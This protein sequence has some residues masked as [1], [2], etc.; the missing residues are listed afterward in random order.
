[1]E[2]F[3]AGLPSRPPPGVAAQAGDAE[4]RGWQTGSRLSRLPPGDSLNRL[5]DTLDCLEAALARPAVVLL[6]R[7]YEELVAVVLARFAAKP[8][9]P[10]P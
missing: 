2:A 4:R 6:G 1:M 5:S 3:N 9:D 8:M 7:A 10:P